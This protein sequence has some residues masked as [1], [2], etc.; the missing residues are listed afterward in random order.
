[1][2]KVQRRRALQLPPA[3]SL[4]SRVP[5]QHQ[6]RSRSARSGTPRFLD[7]GF[8]CIHLFPPLLRSSRDHLGRV[9]FNS[10]AFIGWQIFES[11]IRVSEQPHDRST[12]PDYRPSE[13]DLAMRHFSARTIKFRPL[14]A[15]TENQ[16]ATA[17]AFP[18]S[19]R[20]VFNLQNRT[21]E[22]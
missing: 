2:A 17:T 7:N 19:I 21:L 4:P 15:A 6:R 13:S 10:H 8:I 3:R 5:I 16:L 18:K 22:R 12:F 1:M 9:Y 20:N 14:K 11:L